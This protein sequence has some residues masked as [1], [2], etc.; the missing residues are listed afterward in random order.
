MSLGK[1]Y[2]EKTGINNMY[3]RDKAFAGEVI[4]ALEND[5]WE[6]FINA[7]DQ[8]DNVIQYSST[9]PTW[10][11][12]FVDFEPGK[13]AINGLR[14]IGTIYAGITQI[15]AAPNI[16]LTGGVGSVPL[17]LHGAGNI[18]E[19]VGDYLDIIM[20]NNEN[21][22]WNFT[23][24]AYEQSFEN[25]VKVFE[26][27]GIDANSG[28]AAYHAVDFAMGLGNLMSK[29]NYQTN[30]YLEKGLLHQFFNK[31]P[32]KNLSTDGAQRLD[33]IFNNNDEGLKGLSHALRD[34]IH[35]SKTNAG[36]GA[37]NDLQSLYQNSEQVNK[38]FD[39]YIPESRTPEA[40]TQH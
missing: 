31:T 15:M 39:K 9:N 35:D 30:S 4:Q 7:V 12:E 13:N 32:K 3:S 17:F 22:Q 34:Y 33:R 38:F 2:K 27:L 37:V 16:E 29:E 6:Q 20:A 25:Y 21:R 19:G 36:Y 24:N 5:N 8:R 23:K 28:T 26:N 1:Y 11:N 14:A 40:T 10:I 18:A